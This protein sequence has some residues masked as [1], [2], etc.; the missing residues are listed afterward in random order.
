MSY[1]NRSDN[2]SVTSGRDGTRHFRGNHDFR[3]NQGS[4][5]GFRGRGNAGNRGNRRG[6]YRNL[7]L[8]SSRFGNRFRGNEDAEG[9]VSMSGDSRRRGGYGRGGSNRGRF[10]SSNNRG[11][12]TKRATGGRDYRKMEAWYKV[13]VP[14]GSSLSQN[15]L[16]RMITSVIDG[17][18]D[19]V[20]FHTDSKRAFFFVKGSESA[21]SIRSIS[22]RLTKSDGHKL[23]F[24]VSPAISAPEQPL[25]HSVIE[26]LKVRMSDRYDPA[27]QLLSLSSLYN[28]EV[29]SK[30][31]IN[32]P[33]QTG[34]IMSAV[35]RIIVEHI[36][37]LSGLDVSNNRIGNLSIMSTL[38]K[39]TPNVASLNLGGNQLRA[40]EELEKIKGWTNIAELV[41]DGNDLCSN[42]KDQSTYTSAVRKIFPKVARLDGIELPPPITFD[43]DTELELPQSQGSHFINDD[44]KNL[45]VAFIKDYY[46]IY[47]TDRRRDL[48]PA[49][50]ENAQF[51][52]YVCR[53]PMFEKQS[54]FTNYIEESR[55]LKRIGHYDPPMSFSIQTLLVE[56]VPVLRGILPAKC[57]STSLLK[58]PGFAVCSRAGAGSEARKK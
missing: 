57:L 26:K 29:L 36:P 49:Y 48:M 16:Y 7:S 54:G 3:F 6:N 32:L 45:V 35:T 30:E 4:S 1:N 47:D 41:L 22:R 39:G 2:F 43:L 19:P 46:A 50:H 20:Q 42:F 37:E 21:E 18:F 34:N 10:N 13:M 14:F 9:D 44:I 51:S 24:H 38:V 12:G 15:E 17:P 55:N 23:V 56:A 40:I 53:N 8:S 11:R 52:M 27:T 58:A 25:S 5:R 28:D 33:L 31:G